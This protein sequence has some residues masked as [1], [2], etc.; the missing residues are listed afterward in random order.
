MLMNTKKVIWSSM[1]CNGKDVQDRNNTLPLQGRQDITDEVMVHNMQF[2]S[3]LD[4]C[5]QMSPS[6]QPSIILLQSNF[7]WQCI[8][9][10][11][12]N[13][14]CWLV[15]IPCWLVLIPRWGEVSHVGQ[16][17]NPFWKTAQIFSACMLFLTSATIIGW[18]LCKHPKYPRVLRPAQCQ[19][20]S[21]ETFMQKRVTG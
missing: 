13:F 11:V 16:Q 2:S 5:Y 7:I 12:V 20:A 17:T 19:I 8:L 1:V 9:L 6:S 18:S 4:I 21:S 10:L 15:F 3:W 14:S